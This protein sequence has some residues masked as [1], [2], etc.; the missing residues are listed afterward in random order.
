[1]G[2]KIHYKGTINDISLIDDFCDELKDIASD[3]DWKYSL[4][5]EDIYKPNTSYIDD[6]HQIKGHIP[7]KGI[8]INVHPK[9]ES[10]SFLFDKNGLIRSIVSMTYEKDKAESYDSI[11]TQFAPVDIH[12]SVIKLLKYLKKKYIGNLEVF[13]EGRY[14]ETENRE[15]LTEK[16]DFLNKKMD[17]LEGVLNSLERNENDTLESVVDRIEKIL[18]DRYPNIKIVKSKNQNK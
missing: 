16:I 14:W 5:D 11:K 6:D 17:E 12:M 7:L 4:L 3:M 13:D 15:L 2:I 1:M 18:K 9:A 10:L 8:V